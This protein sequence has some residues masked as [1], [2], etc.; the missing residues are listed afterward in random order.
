MPPFHLGYD[1]K[2]IKHMS[3]F[4]SNTMTLSFLPQMG[5]KDNTQITNLRTPLY[6]VTKYSIREW[7]RVTFVGYINITWIIQAAKHF[8]C[9][10]V[11]VIIIKGDQQHS[12]TSLL[13]PFLISYLYPTAFFKSWLQLFCDF[14][15][16]LDYTLLVMYCAT[17][18]LVS[19]YAHV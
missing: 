13:Y 3:S 16:G 6:W 15:S 8:L 11:W 1:E 10:K 9:H 4:R 17:S 14:W 19:I 18:C 2:F 12:Y 7:Q 5:I